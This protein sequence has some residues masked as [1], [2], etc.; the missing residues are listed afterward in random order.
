MS[1]FIFRYRARI[2][3][4]GVPCSLG[5]AVYR[6]TVLLLHKKKRVYFVIHSLMATVAAAVSRRGGVFYVLPIIFGDC[7][8]F[9]Y[10]CPA[11]EVTTTTEA[12]Y[13]VIVI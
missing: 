11:A 8:E 4:G 1:S 5:A 12:E 3:Y 10:V 6:G 13:G 7:F 2:G 9:V